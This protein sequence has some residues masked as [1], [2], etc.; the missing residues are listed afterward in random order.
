MLLVL[1]Y[2]ET[3]T[4]APSFW[5]S[6][7]TLA[8]ESGHTVVCCTLRFGDNDRYNYDVIQDMGELN[9][10]IIYAAS[11]KDKFEAVQEHGYIAENAIW[12]DDC[13][14]FIS[15]GRTHGD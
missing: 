7:V 4:A 11:Y 2:D 9:V 5:D 12:I 6:V 8:Q 1:D 14:Q 3:Y 13:P 10:P 15:I